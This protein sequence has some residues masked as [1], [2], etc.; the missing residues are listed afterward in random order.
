MED[1]KFKI[2]TGCDNGIF[3][4]CSKRFLKLSN[5]LLVSIGGKS[6]KLFYVKKKNDKI[7]LKLL[8]VSETLLWSP[9]SIFE[10]NN[11]DIITTGRNQIVIYK[12]LVKKF[13]LV[14]EIHDFGLAELFQVV[15][16]QNEKIIISSITDLLVILEKKNDKYQLT[17]YN[18]CRAHDMEYISKNN[19]FLI[20]YFP[21]K[22]NL[23]I[24]DFS[25][26]KISKKNL[27]F[28]YKITQF[29]FAKNIF[30]FNEKFLIFQSTKYLFYL[31]LKMEEIIFVVEL[32]SVIYDFKYLKDDKYLCVFENKKVGLISIKNEFVIEDT[33][34]FEDVNPFQIIDIEDFFLLLCD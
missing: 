14:E 8:D 34:I 29:R 11:K 25:E 23:S 16:C 19:I 2:L 21:E 17:K 4:K 32:D 30:Y 18:V 9:L 22:T 15:Q 1:I 3:I 24:L 28:G 31:N 13:K 33:K 26:E 12:I 6:L 20:E 10:L 7:K 27:K 5:N